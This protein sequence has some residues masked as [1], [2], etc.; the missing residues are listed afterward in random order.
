MVKWSLSL[1]QE[2]ALMQSPCTGRRVGRALRA[3]RAPQGASSNDSLEGRRDPSAVAMWR[4][5][6][7]KAFPWIKLP[8]LRLYSVGGLM[9]GEQ[10]RTIVQ[11]IDSLLKA[12]A[13]DY[14]VGRTPGCTI[15]NPAT[16]TRCMSSA[17]GARLEPNRDRS[18]R[19]VISRLRSMSSIRSATPRRAPSTS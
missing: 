7:R 5:N 15:G 8:R 14:H 6:L 12:E 19:N 11:D 18:A 9:S 4:A 1:R 3:C 10:L 16:D 13:T 2:L 17:R